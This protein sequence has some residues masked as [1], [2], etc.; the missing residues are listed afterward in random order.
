MVGVPVAASAVSW[1]ASAVIG[2]IVVAAA[3]GI[4]AAGAL[5]FHALGGRFA[6]RGEMSNKTHRNQLD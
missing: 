3:G 4:A 5:A 1:D 6:T 2:R